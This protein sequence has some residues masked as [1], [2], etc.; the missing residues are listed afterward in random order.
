M[1]KKS[2][3]KKGS[4]KKALADADLKHYVET[5]KY[6]KL[7]DKLYQQ[8]IAELAALAAKIDGIP[9]DK[10][11][12]FAHN[13]QIAQEVDDTIKRLASRITAVVE[14]GSRKEWTAACVKSDQFIG[15]IM[16]VSKLTRHTLQT[17]QD[18]NLEALAAFTQREV[19]GLDLS[20]RVWKY[21]API[22][23]EVEL[24]VDTTDK[25]YKHGIN[26]QKTMTKVERAIGTGMSAQKLSQEVRSCLIEP[27]KLFRRVRDKYG[28]LHLSKA[29]KLYHPGQGV[30]RSSYK[31]AMR[32]TRSEINMAYRQ[33]DHLRW[34]QLDFVVGIKIELSNNHTC[35][36]PKTGK[37]VPFYD[38]CDELAGN[39]PKDFKFV[40]W[41][42]QCRCHATP[43]LKDL[44]EIGNGEVTKEGEYREMPSANEVTD[45]PEAFKN[46]I[47]DNSKRIAGWK[48]MPYYLRDNTENAVS[49]LC[50]V[51]QGLKFEDKYNRR[52]LAYKLL[53]NDKNY[54]DV[55]FNA[56]NAG[57]KATHIR[58]NFDQDGGRYEKNVQQA[59]FSS[60][61][62]VIFGGEYS[63]VIN[64]RFTEGLWDGQPFEVMG[65][66]TGTENNVLRGLKHSAKK[67]ATKIAVLDFPNGHF[68]E[69][70]LEKAMTR[71]Y[72][73]EKLNDGQ[74]IQFDRVVCVQEKKI[75]YDK[76]FEVKRTGGSV[77]QYT[78]R[79]AKIGGSGE[80][81]IIANPKNAS[82]GVNNTDLASQRAKPSV[83]LKSEYKTI[84]DV[85]D[86]I[87][88]LRK[89]EGWKLKDGIEGFY[90]TKPTGA[91]AVAG[92]SDGYGGL[93]FDR[94][95]VLSAFN[96]IAKGE[97]PNTTELDAL[98]TLWHE[99]NHNRHIGTKP[100]KMSPRSTSFM[101][102]A[103][104]WY[105]QKTLK[106]DFLDKIGMLNGADLDKVFGLE[107]NG[108]KNMVS[109]F[110]NL[111][112]VLHI[113]EKKVLL[114][115]EK[116]LFEKKYENMSQY[117]YEAL[118]DG[119]LQG[120]NGKIARE[121]KSHL[122]DKLITTM[123]KQ[124][125]QKFAEDNG[126]KILPIID[127]NNTQRK[128]ILA[129]AKKRHEQRTQEQ[130][131]NIQSAWNAR[132]AKAYNYTR[133]IDRAEE[134][135]QSHGLDRSML[136]E[137]LKS[138]QGDR[139]DF[140]LKIFDL[141]D[142]YDD[143]KRKAE[144]MA[145][146]RVRML[147]DIKEKLL[148]EGG[149]K[150]KIQAARIDKYQKQVNSTKNKYAYINGPK[151]EASIASMQKRLDEITAH[152]AEVRKAAEEWAKKR[153]G[154]A[155]A[156]MP[157]ELGPKSVYLEG[158]D[159]LFSKDFFDLLKASP[160][161]EL[162]LDKEGG[163]YES[164]NG[165]VVHI[166]GKTRLHSSRV[167]RKKVIYH[168]YGH[169][170]ADQRGLL[171]D[172]E[173]IDMMEAQRKTLKKKFGKKDK[174][175]MRW[176]R[177]Y[178]YDKK[179]YVYKKEE[180]SSLAE[181]IDYRID[182]LR[183]RITKMSEDTF[184]KRGISKADLIEE[185]CATAD[186]LKAL[187][188]KYGYGHS[189][190]YFRDPDMQKHEY[191]AHAFENTFNGNTVFRKF[192]PDIYNEMIAYIGQV[193]NKDFA[194]YWKM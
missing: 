133:Y 86:T 34:Q 25:Y 44:D 97:L 172:K 84:D 9:E 14:T 129:A 114:S 94:K 72:G 127:S 35:L 43:I 113:D 151:Y 178:D 29:A 105:S 141:S 166:E 102:L 50:E 32:L 52:N 17:Y 136:D 103:N 82:I 27:K 67:R 92:Q 70:V 139:T 112:D 179:A 187:V 125:W 31:N 135:I 144:V 15:Q 41:H 174:K 132:R 37:P 123:H 121:V 156:L 119:G 47:A 16:N 109:S 161:L 142:R 11:F 164:W 181:Y 99:I 168:E 42:P 58:H 175:P 30:Y 49:S 56:S 194:T 154:S 74:F 22:K 104:E 54:T 118:I 110:Q 124:W 68:D 75:V 20:R 77:K 180:C 60:G 190:S 46:Y 19:D 10:P 159:Y 5:E 107:S 90:F 146:K 96:K 111:I 7:V 100:M 122:Q 101:E 24:A 28:N 78:P 63:N 155:S 165:R 26:S 130:K 85:M 140:M 81:A 160:K 128:K 80:S 87:N 193:K 66:T 73:L 184:T 153:R 36:S 79:T 177:T 143:L 91:M 39:Y 176:L 152:R 4:A 83:V 191:L 53:S 62:A 40:G 170:I 115:L 45:V 163:S 55:T 162:V 89:A 6:V 57:L 23:D 186:S 173:L 157:K 167:Q 48:N 183:S 71:Y 93:Y 189:D 147:E 148:K 12:S 88:E 8:A 98:S 2:S 126:L 21:V 192:M 138:K 134:L 69:S 18:R 131:D 188:R 65:C 51:N 171:G 59:G 61:H 108:Y 1:A 13:K 145:N 149:A 137:F 64:Q 38:I 158:E 169:A 185:L 106:R 33:S 3:K 76:V 120:V 117:L 182:A 95:N 116:S 150:A